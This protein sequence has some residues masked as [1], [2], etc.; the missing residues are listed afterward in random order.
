MQY[1]FVAIIISLASMVLAALIYKSKGYRAIYYASLIL[2]AQC[3]SLFLCLFWLGCYYFTGEGVNDAVIYTLT[4]SLYGADFKDYVAPFVVAVLLIG[5]LLFLSWRFMQGKNVQKERK[6][7]A[8]ITAVLLT[9]FA[10]GIS[11]ALLQFTNYSK[12]P[13]EVDGSDFSRY[14][15]TPDT[16]INN[17]KYNLVYIYAES[18]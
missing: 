16:R 18:R 9:F 2:L 15:I 12:P 6:H 10:V 3:I 17:P 11:P 5:L 14:Y 7:Y 1:S 4:R 13:A 8:S